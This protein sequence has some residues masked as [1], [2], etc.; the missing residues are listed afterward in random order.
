MSL[1]NISP[2]LFSLSL[3]LVFAL[4]TGSC[5]ESKAPRTADTKNAQAE[6][7]PISSNNEKKNSSV[8][9][10]S[11]KNKI[12]AL[13]EGTW[14]GPHLILTVTASGATLEFECAHGAIDQEIALDANGRFDVRGTYEGEAGAAT[15]ISISHEDGNGVSK[16]TTST[17]HP[18]RYTGRVTG[19]TMTLTVTL[20]DP[21]NTLGTFT[22]TSGAT[23]R[24]RKCL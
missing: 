13:P 16:A 8:A 20:T 4:Q 18:A 2:T 9:S 12:A 10:N 23:P 7:S 19:Q 6:S 5:Q 11:V 14:G 22:L 21:E 15:D 3:T 17:G 1:I 24:L